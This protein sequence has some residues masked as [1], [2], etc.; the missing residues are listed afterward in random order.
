MDL[1]IF[2]KDLIYYPRRGN[3]SIGALHLTTKC[4]FVVY[5]HQRLMNNCV[6]EC[7]FSKC[8][9]IY[10]MGTH[11]ILQLLHT[12]IYPFAIGFMIAGVNKPFCT[13]EL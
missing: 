6:D 13:S 8:V 10:D 1:T 4:N 9:S 3:Y 5:S 11:F 2:C 7:R 12:R